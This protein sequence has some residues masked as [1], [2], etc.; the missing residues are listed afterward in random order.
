MAAKKGEGKPAAGK[1]NAPKK[2][3]TK[4][5]SKPAKTATATAA[6]PT[7]AEPAK[8]AVEVRKKGTPVREM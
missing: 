3:S 5:A 6:Q 1:G 4:P 7:Q 8:K 2:T